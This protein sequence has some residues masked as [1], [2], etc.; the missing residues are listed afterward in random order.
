MALIRVHPFPPPCIKSKLLWSPCLCTPCK[1]AEYKP[2]QCILRSW[3]QSYLAVLR[4]RAEGLKPSQQCVALQ[5]RNR[6]C[7]TL[8]LHKEEG[9]NIL[10][11]LSDRTDV[12]V[13]NF[14]PGVMEKWGLGPEVLSFTSICPPLR[15]QVTSVLFSAGWAHVSISE[16]IA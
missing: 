7:I 3:A 6:R 12:L 9:R 1:G 10:R 14:R 2:L 8:D 15:C 11:R 5:G 13:E 4:H 16:R